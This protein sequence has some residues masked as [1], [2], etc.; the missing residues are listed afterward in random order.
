M[1]REGFFVR[2]LVFI[3]GEISDLNAIRAEMRGDDLL[4]AADGGAR[5]VLALDRLPDLLVGDLDS[6]DPAEL[7][8]MEAAG[9]TILRSPVHKDETD[10]ELAIDAAIE[11]GADEVVLVGATGGRL[12]Q[13]LAN[14]LIL[15][16]RDWGATLQILDGEQRALLIRAPATLEIAGEP[17][18]LVS[19]IPLSAE[20]T[21][22]TYTGLVYPLT[23]HTLT[24]G[25]TRGVSNELAAPSARI[26]VASG[27]L[28]L[29][30]GKGARFV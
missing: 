3:N 25:S 22:I 7:G 23:N 20:V 8:Q 13:T 1:E 27:L 19:A 18:T 9:V 15:A 24:L 4:V 11:A 2:A 30:V 5:Y 10:L 28:L 21:G 26:D 16:Q 6:V 12:D 17:G 14:L 29:I